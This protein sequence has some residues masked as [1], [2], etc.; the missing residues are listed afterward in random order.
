LQPITPTLILSFAPTRVRKLAIISRGK[1]A[2]AEAKAVFLR[3]FLLLFIVDV[4][5]F[6]RDSVDKFTQ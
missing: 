3:K 1:N 2:P 5:Y 4:F 6:K